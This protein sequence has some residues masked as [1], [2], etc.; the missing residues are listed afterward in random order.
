[1]NLTRDGQLHPL[2]RLSPLVDENIK[3]WKTLPGQHWYYQGIK[4]A[5]R[6]AMVLVEHGEQSN[7][8][9]PIP[10]L[11]V[12]RFG[13]GEVFFVGINSIWRWRY[14]IGNKITRRFWSQGMQYLGLPHLLGHVDRVNIDTSGQDFEVGDAIEVHLRVMD[15]RYEP[16]SDD[17]TVLLCKNKETSEVVEFSMGSAGVK[18]G[19]Y[20]GEILLKEGEWTLMVQGL[21]DQKEKIIMVKKPRYET[22]NPAMNKPLLMDMAKVSDGQFIGPD[23]LK[24]LPDLLADKKELMRNVSELEIWDKGLFLFIF[25]MAA[26]LEWF[27]RKRNDLV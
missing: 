20:Q 1:M 11:A 3:L 24:D 25:M 7:E 21:E 12:H 2:T 27:I 22:Y 6:S 15:E 23:E 17:S 18:S 9:G 4:K 26:T 8:Y 13:K 14:K 19:R 16:W 10:L 5:K